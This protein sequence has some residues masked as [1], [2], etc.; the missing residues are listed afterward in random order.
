M[1]VSELTRS[2]IMKR[3][4]VICRLSQTNF[5]I[6]SRNERLPLRRSAQVVDAADTRETKNGWMTTINSDV[7]VFDSDCAVGQVGAKLTKRNVVVCSKS[8]RGTAIPQ[9]DT[10]TLKFVLANH[11][12]LP[13]FRQLGATGSLSFTIYFC[14]FNDLSFSSPLPRLTPFLDDAPRWALS[15]F[16]LPPLPNVSNIPSVASF[17]K[18]NVK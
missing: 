12:V 14:R 6:S 3:E 4:W 16:D 8:D 9:K 18:R 11:L 13:G 7:I 17:P 2:Q 1:S 15:P 5:R 10:Q